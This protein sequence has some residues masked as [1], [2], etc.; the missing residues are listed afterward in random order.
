MTAIQ[1]ISSTD[2]DAMPVINT[3]EPIAVE[4]ASDVFETASPFFVGMQTKIFASTPFTPKKVSYSFDEET[5]TRLILWAAAGGAAAEKF[6]ASMKRATYIYGPT[7]A[8]KTALTEAFASRTGRSMFT[9][10]CSEETTL[11]DLFGSWKLCGPDGMK[12]I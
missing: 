9:I 8:G 4:Q 7:G 6:K 2:S 5:L 10:Q 1:T 11:S 3:L 12:W